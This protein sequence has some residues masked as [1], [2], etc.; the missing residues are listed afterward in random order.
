MVDDAPEPCDPEVM[1][2]TKKLGLAAKVKGALAKPRKKTAKATGK[3]AKTPKEPKVA[4]G[5]R[6]P[7]VKG[8]SKKD[9]AC[10]LMLRKSGA[11]LEDFKAIGWNEGSVTLFS[12]WVALVV[13]NGITSFTIEKNGGG[14]KVYKAAA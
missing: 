14:E 10:R 5:E 1:T 4:K 7:R 9:Q 13:R 8:E 6:K 2:K 3:A 11:T 12:Q